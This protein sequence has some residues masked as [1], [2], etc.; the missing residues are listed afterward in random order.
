MYAPKICRIGRLGEVRLVELK[1]TAAGLGPALL[2]SES[3]RDLLLRGFFI[4]SNSFIGPT[5]RARRDQSKARNAKRSVVSS[6]ASSKTD[7]AGHSE[8]D[9]VR[10]KRGSMAYG[11]ALGD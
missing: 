3:A 6:L 8:V 10:F 11:P 4:C 5:W 9:G 1:S 7:Q 2:I